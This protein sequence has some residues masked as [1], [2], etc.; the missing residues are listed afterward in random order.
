MNKPLFFAGA[1]LAC[2]GGVPNFEM[3]AAF[4]IF[5]AGAALMWGSFDA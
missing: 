1:A 3:L 5:A 2:A 4:F